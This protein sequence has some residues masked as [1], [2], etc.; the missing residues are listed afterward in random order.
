MAINRIFDNYKFKRT[1]IGGSKKSEKQM[2]DETQSDEKTGR[3]VN[4]FEY[5]KLLINH[6][7]DKLN[8]I[9]SW[10]IL[11]K[12]IAIILAIVSL[13]SLYF[14]NINLFVGLV[15]LSILSQL[16]SIYLKKKENKEMGG[17]D[18]CL[19]ITNNEI[20]QKTGIVLDKQN[21]K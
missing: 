1:Y 15:I 2:F 13:I 21:K 7:D 11:L 19:T 18:F 4:W 8:V 6:F 3:D 12:N 10:R 9:F 16:I 5:R 20:K 17:Y 14:K